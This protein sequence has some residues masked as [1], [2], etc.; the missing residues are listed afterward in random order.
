MNVALFVTCLTDTFF[1]RAGEAVVRVLRHYGCQVSFPAAQ[2]CCGQPA[3]NSGFHNEARRLAA[4]LVDVFA[5]HPCDCIV[6]PSASCAAMVQHHGPELLAG[7]PHRAAAAQAVA[8]RTF[9]FGRFLHERL[10]VDIAAA[11][12][13]REPVT[14]HYPCHARDS[15]SPAEL[16]AWLTPPLCGSTNSGAPLRLPPHV[17]QCCGFGGLFS[18]D[19]PEVSG[20]MLAEKLDGLAATGA[21][22][23]VCNEAACAL[24][25]AGGAHRRGLPLRFQHLAECLAEALGLMEPEA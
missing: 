9:E 18:V 23:V 1:P 15:Y 19:Y 20:A 4:H 12:Q 2:T 7:D 16:Q 21:R 3:Y 25:L 11:L 24:Q 22:L 14:F 8:G 5:A 10:Q 6:T 17:D 13:W